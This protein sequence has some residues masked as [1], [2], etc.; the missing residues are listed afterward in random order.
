[1]NTQNIVNK[2][3]IK[4]NVIPEPAHSTNPLTGT[5]LSFYNAGYAFLEPAFIVL[6]IIIYTPFSL[7]NILYSTNIVNIT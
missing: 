7:D 1:M 2:L 3:M 4:F 5:I 6:I